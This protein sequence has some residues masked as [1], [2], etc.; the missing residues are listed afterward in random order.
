MEQIA[1]L[2]LSAQI[3]QLLVGP[4]VELEAIKFNLNNR[5]AVWVSELATAGVICRNQILGKSLDASSYVR[6]YLSLPLNRDQDEVEAN[7]NQGAQTKYYEFLVIFDAHLKFEL[8][9][10][11]VTISSLRQEQKSSKT[12][13]TPSFGKNL[14]SMTSNRDWDDEDYFVP[15]DYSL[16]DF[17]Y[18]ICEAEASNIEATK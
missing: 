8:Y 2:T 17:E 7:S 5:D 15:Q 12:N 10:R 18:V 6:F 3:K 11:V 13:S 16:E 9:K 14:E 4:K 1:H